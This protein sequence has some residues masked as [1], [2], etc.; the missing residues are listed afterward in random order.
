MAVKSLT[1][2]NLFALNN[3]PPLYSSPGTAPSITAE[4]QEEISEFYTRHYASGLDHLL[5]T[6]WYSSE[7]LAHLRQDPEL[8]DFVSF[9]LEHFKMKSDDP[10]A[11]NN[12]R[13]LEA[14]LVWQLIVMPCSRITDPSVGELLPRIEVLESLITGNILNTASIP[15]EPRTDQIPGTPASRLNELAFW[16][17]IGCITA[18][19]DDLPDAITLREVDAG[20]NGMRSTLGMLESRDVLY[21][22]AIARH[23]GGRL[24]EFMLRP[25]VA[26]NDDP[27]LDVN[28]LKVA[29]DFV[30]AEEQRGTTQVVQRVCSMALR[31]WSLQKQ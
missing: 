18:A 10:N 17:R 25:L 26:V 4:Q 9:C 1:M 31:A 24:P 21:S 22:I 7:G 30:E 23:I 3:V 27:T 6:S 8:L 20:L 5:E 28:K 11:T 2:N 14:R 16:N 29:H 12:N 15:S 19:R 13:S